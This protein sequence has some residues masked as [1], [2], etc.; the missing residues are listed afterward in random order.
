MLS[1]IAIGY[2]NGDNPGYVT[3][4]LTLPTSTE[5]AEDVTITWTSSNPSAISSSGTVNRQAND[6]SVTLTVRA[7]KDTASAERSFA[8]T[9]IRQRSRAVE[10]AKGEGHILIVWV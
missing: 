9:V 3:R 6:V 1:H 4:N 5:E 2:Q 10:Q 8:L 7:E